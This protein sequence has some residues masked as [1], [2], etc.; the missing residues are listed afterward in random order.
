MPIDLLDFQ[1]VRVAFLGADGFGRPVRVADGL[2]DIFL[3]DLRIGRA[4]SPRGIG[5]NIRR[6]DV[7]LNRFAA[8]RRSRAQRR[9]VRPEVPRDSENHNDGDQERDNTVAVPHPVQ[10]NSR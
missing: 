4:G 6:P 8:G 3:S 10:F 2:A 7:G 1:A 5:I 9:R